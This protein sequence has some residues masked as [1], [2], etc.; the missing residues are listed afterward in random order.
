MTASGSL[1]PIKRQSTTR[2]LAALALLFNLLAH[3]SPLGMPAVERGGIEVCTAYG[4]TVIP[5]DKSAPAPDPDHHERVKQC[6][7]CAVHAAALL[8]PPMV[9]LPLSVPHPRGLQ[10]AE[11]S[12]PLAS[13][14]TGFD[15]LSRAPPVIS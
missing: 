4:L 7:V 1:P 15:H 9:A 3:L 13:L 14:A 12:S 5:A 10:P 11:R 6:P 8:A 2:A